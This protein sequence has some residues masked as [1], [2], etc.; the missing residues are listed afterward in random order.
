MS[1]AYLPDGHARP[2]SWPEGALGAPYFAAARREELVVQRCRACGG[3][4]WLPEW[5]CHRCRSFDLGYEAVAPEGV[6][7]TW[8][9]AWH[10]T[11]PTLDGHGPY[12]VV[13][14]ALPHAGGVRMVGNLLGDPADEVVDRRAGAGAVRAPRGRRRPARLHVGAVAP[15]VRAPRTTDLKGTP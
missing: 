12:V 6:I 2:P 9:R 3:W 7:D 1:G 8:Q 4:Q 10:P 11:H 14:V 13:V 5:L 15:R